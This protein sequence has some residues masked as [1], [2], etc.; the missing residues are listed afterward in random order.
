MRL[1]AFLFGLIWSACS[2]AAEPEP[3]PQIEE[4]FQYQLVIPPQPTTA[5]TGRVEVVELF[6]YGCPHCY[7]FEPYLERWVADRADNVDFVRIPSVLNPSWVPLARA[8]YTAEVLGVV[9]QVHRPLFDA[10]HRDKRRIDTEEDIANFFAEHGVDKEKFRQ[11]FHSFAVE[12]K[13]NRSKVLAQRYGGS[14]VP[15]IVIQGK[16]RTSGDLA[17]S[18]ENIVAVIDYLVAKESEPAPVKAQ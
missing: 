2:L 12:T 14:G 6:W 9:D 10:I 16:Y 5:S 15:A 1:T 13:L 11:T 18:Y 17:G 8:Y 4:G 3:A 7:H